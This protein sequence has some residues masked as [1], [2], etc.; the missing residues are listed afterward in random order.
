MNIINF[1]FKVLPETFWIEMNISP[2]II[3]SDLR[4]NTLCSRYNAHNNLNEHV[5]I[6]L[7]LSFLVKMTGRKK[8]MEN[9]IRCPFFTTALKTVHLHTLAHVSIHIYILYIV[10]GVC[11][12]STKSIILLHTYETEISL[13]LTLQRAV[14]T[15]NDAF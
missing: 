8:K 12:P 14:F 7:Q 1:I 6:S 3:I 10:D 2:C 13:I 4:N 9:I 11:G 15:C 5:L